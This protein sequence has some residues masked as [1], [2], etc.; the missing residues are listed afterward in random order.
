MDVYVYTVENSGTKPEF[1][2]IL[3]RLKRYIFIGKDN[4]SFEKIIFSPKAAVWLFIHKPL[5]CLSRSASSC[6]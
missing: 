3:W 5:S 6:A 4:F 2:D 1:I